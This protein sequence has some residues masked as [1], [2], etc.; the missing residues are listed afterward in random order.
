M[1]SGVRTILSR[2]ADI[3]WP[4]TCAVET[5]G[6]PVDRPRRH[7]CSACFATLPFHE[8]GGS[9][10]VCGA[11]VPA[12]TPHSFVCEACAT[13]PPPYERTCSA[14]D[15]AEPF[16]K[17]VQAFKYNRASW[18]AE[19]FADLMEGAV[20]TRLDSRAVDAVFPVPLHPN[21]QRKRGY[22]Q[23][24]LLARALARRLSRRC[25]ERSLARIRDTP[26]Q[27]LLN[28]ADRRQNLKDAFAAA[29]PSFIRGRTI[30]LV[31][32]VTTTGSTLAAA[33]EPLRAAGAAH[34]WCATL[35]RATYER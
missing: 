30:L 19:D 24:A 29:R 5:C 31:D 16:D 14:L 4:R 12:H 20:R 33:A 1:G 7:I 3:V 22:N 10:G 21:R 18:L 8:P 17:L 2:L 9:C 26:K 6:R 11:P 27:S 32:D 15:Y 28:G 34:V 25:D 35:A 23:A 13:H